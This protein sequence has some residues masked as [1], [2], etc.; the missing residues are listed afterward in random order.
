MILIVD[1]EIFSVVDSST[2]SDVLISMVD[3]SAISYVSEFVELS[4][5]GAIVEENGSL[6]LAI[7][8]DNIFSFFLFFLDRIKNI[9]TKR[10]L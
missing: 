9:P 10:L 3:E 5:E 4:G 8:N 7:E 2:N 6:V 1:E